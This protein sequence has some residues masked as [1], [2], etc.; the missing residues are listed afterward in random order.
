[1]ANGNPEFDLEACER[2]F[3]PIAEA[4]AQFARR[5]NLALV[6]YDHGSPYWDLLFAHPIGGHGKLVL[7]RGL[8]RGVT[9]SAVVWR[10]DYDSFTRRIRRQE[11][12]EVSCGQIELTDELDR[13]LD[14]VLGWRLNEQFRSVGGYERIWST[15]TRERFLKSQPVLP[16]PLARRD[17]R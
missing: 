4:I 12:R 14:E 6:R 3:A 7:G 15:M 13:L 1:M 9:V 5:R 8:T 2:F 16:V 17:A 10:D 11:E